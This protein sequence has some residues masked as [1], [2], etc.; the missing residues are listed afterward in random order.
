MNILLIS[1]W[2]PP[3]N[4][5]AALRIYAYAKYLTKSG[6]DVTVL[7][8]ATKD[9][10]QESSTDLD[11]SG[12]K[13]VRVNFGTASS[14]DNINKIRQSGVNEHNI[15]QSFTINILRIC[16]KLKNY[17]F[18]NF[19]TPEDFWLLRAHSK[20]KNL[21]HHTCFDAVIS[22]SGPISAHF[23]AYF[24]KKKYVRILWFA[25]Y[26]DM[27]SH[28]DLFAKPKWPL[29]FIQRRLE[30]CINNAADYLI[31]VSEP[32]RNL[33]S[34]NSN[35]RT[36][37]IENG[38]F[39]ED[40]LLEDYSDA[41]DDDGIF[42][43]AHTGTIYAKYDIEPLLLAICELIEDNRIVRDKIRM[44]FYGDNVTQLEPMIRQYELTDI[45][46]LKGKISRQESLRIQRKSS[47]LLFLGHE[48]ALTKGILTGKIFEY[49][50]AAKPIIA[51]GIT[52]D[53]SA[54][55]LIHETNTGYVCGT[56]VQHI[57][58]AIMNSVGMMPLEPNVE[59][60]NAY[61]RDRLVDKLCAVLRHDMPS[62]LTT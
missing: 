3:L 54:G 51:I 60:I 24:L 36:L 52:E 27:W 23:I 35:T 5:I 37:L 53:S 4:T 50:I 14:I 10:S 20:A 8:S 57:K 45:C 17:L 49:L 1:Y 61:R 29:S 42:Y 31:T 18:G 28:N 6:Y 40:V 38:F 32:L 43:L 13:I 44:L 39:P 58:A 7:T 34:G 48:S 25:D 21:C 30:K 26:R 41:N 47:A 16:E 62:R 11:L 46:M 2:F 56:D 19:F 12:I 22:S 33:L 9:S 55:K 15:G 59:A